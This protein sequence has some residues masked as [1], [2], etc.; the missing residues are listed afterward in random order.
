MADDEREDQAIETVRNWLIGAYGPE[1]HVTTSADSVGSVRALLLVTTTTDHP[2][3]P[4]E[5]LQAWQELIA[6]EQR[7]LEQAQRALRGQPNYARLAERAAADEDPSRR[8]ER[9]AELW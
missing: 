5:V 8:A 3:I 6:S 2:E 1:H 9:E 4:L 7:H